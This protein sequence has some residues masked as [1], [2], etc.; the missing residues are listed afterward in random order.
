MEKNMTTI[1]TTGNLTK[2]AITKTDKNGN[3]Y[4]LLNLAEN[5][6]KRDTEGKIVKDE[7]GFGVK[8]D[9]FYYSI[10]VNDKAGALSASKLEKGQSIKVVGKANI[11]KESDANNHIQYII[12]SISAYSIDTDPYRSNTNAGGNMSK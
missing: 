5:I 9:S 8:L 1:I 6:Y 11:K 4:V 12:D 7:N 2:D 10:F 3:D